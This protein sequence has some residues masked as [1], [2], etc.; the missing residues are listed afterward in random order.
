M[1]LRYARFARGNVKFRKYAP[2]LIF[3]KGPLRG[4]YSRRG[5]CAEGNLLFKL[6][7]LACSGKEMYHFCFVLLCIREQ[8]PTVQAGALIFKGAI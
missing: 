4:A 8:I 1:V 3:F 6:I 7:G 2:G 5:L